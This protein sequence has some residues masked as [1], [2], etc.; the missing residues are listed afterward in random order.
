MVHNE[1]GDDPE[2][3]F[4]QFDKR[5]F[6]AASLG[7][8]H[9]ARLTSGEEV[10]VKIQYPGI[11]RTIQ[12][13][14]RN[15]FLFMLPARLRQGLGKHQG[16]VRRPADRGWS[17]RPTTSW[18]P[19]DLEQARPLF[20]DDDGIVVPRVYPQFSTSRVLTMERL[21]GVHL[22][23]FLARDPSQEERNEV[24]RSCCGPGIG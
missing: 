17:R 20:R 4:A 18:K 1:L 7:Q 16:P 23:E 19:A 9:A 13:D 10:A 24:A 6:A 22:T 3:L 11:A 21:E 2:N 8:V 14:F 5:A 15:L 12:S